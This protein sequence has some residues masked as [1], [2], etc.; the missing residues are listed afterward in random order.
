MDNNREAIDHLIKCTGMKQE[1]VVEVIKEVVEEVTVVE[2]VVVETMEE[3]T[4]PLLK[5]VEV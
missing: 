5:P 3:E 1:E 4:Q 2:T